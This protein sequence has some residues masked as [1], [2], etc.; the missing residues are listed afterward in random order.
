MRF[1]LSPEDVSAEEVSDWL[2]QLRDLASSDE[3]ASDGRAGPAGGRHGA[4]RLDGA[5][6]EAGVDAA[7]DGTADGAWADGGSASH[8]P[9]GR[10]GAHGG[11]ASQNG[12]RVTAGAGAGEPGWDGTSEAGQGGRG[13]GR[14]SAAGARRGSARAGHRAGGAASTEVLGEGRSLWQ[15]T[16]PVP[17]GSPPAARAG[18]AARGGSGGQA[19]IGDQLR[20]PI[21]WCEML[22]CISHHSSPAA[23]GEADVRASAIAAGWRYD[24]LERLTCPQCLQSNPWFWPAH[25][26]VPWDREKA[27]AMVALMA[28]HDRLMAAAR[29]RRDRAAGYPDA[30]ADDRDRGADH[31]D[32]AADDRDGAA[33][34]RDRGADH[35]DGADN[36]RDRGADDRDRSAD[37]RDRGADDTDR[38]PVAPVPPARPAAAPA[39]EPWTRGRHR[40]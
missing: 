39:P 19:V 38:A 9:G 18:R 31:R 8:V 1:T 36:D 14:A 26:V 6:G 40:K 12:R 3:A 37:D 22:Q 35:R 4:A 21:A 7:R 27:T 15:L 34:D 5:R 23:L 20:I 10:H 17:P 28:A 24:R 25:P 33:E 11:E 32:G 2:A 30:A 29:G 16:R 13:S